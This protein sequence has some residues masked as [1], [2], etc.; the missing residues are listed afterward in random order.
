M[1]IREIS[2]SKLNPAKYNPRKN[3]QPDDPEYKRIEKSLDEF[4][5]VEPLV[6][7]E[8]TGNLVSGHQRLK[9]CIARGITEVTCSVVNI[10]DPKKEAALNI[11][12]NN[13]FG[14]WDFPKLKD[15]V[16]EIDDG[17]FDI[18]IIGFDTD[19]L[20]K[21]FGYGNDD[22]NQ[23][24]EFKDPVIKLQISADTWIDIKDSLIDTV[25]QMCIKFGIIAIFP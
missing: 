5:M 3:L 1:D 10:E 11:A 12:L 23:I 25:N 17:S 16:S 6:W 20:E 9:I 22:N 7:N 21:M 14:K 2:I 8:A 13:S 18:D 15:I 19:D 24:T 4:D